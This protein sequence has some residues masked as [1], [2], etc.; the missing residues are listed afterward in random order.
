MD[1]TGES[2]IKSV[3]DALQYAERVD[4]YEIGLEVLYAVL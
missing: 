4:I 1:Y 3:T 2:H